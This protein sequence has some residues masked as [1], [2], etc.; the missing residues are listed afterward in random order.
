M[1]KIKNLGTTIKEKLN[2][3]M[4]RVKTDK[5]FCVILIAIV[6]AVIAA[7]IALVLVLGGGGA[8][9]GLGLG[10]GSGNNTDDGTK[11]AYTVSVKSKGG[12]PLGEVDVAI[13][14]A[15]D[16]NNLKDYAKTDENGLVNFQLGEDGN[17]IIVLTGVPKGYAVEESYTFDGTTAVISLTSSV[18]KDDNLT[19]AV[20]NEGDVM[21]DFTITT[22]DG[23]SYTLSEILKEKKMVLINYWYTTCSWCV[24]EFPVMAEAYEQYKDEIEIIAVNPMG[25]GEAAVKNFAESM[26]LPFPVVE[27]PSGWANVFSVTGY[28]TSVLIDQYGVVC[29]I[30]RGAITSLSP[31]VSAFEHFTA[32]DYQQKLCNGTIKSLYQQIKPNVSMPSS[33]EIASVINKGDIE[34]TY[35]PEEGDSAEYTWPFVIGDKNGTQCIYA[36]N[37]GIEDSYAILYADVTLKKGQALKL[38]YLSSTEKG[39]DIMYVIVNDEPI[40]NISGWEAEEKWQSC[41]PCIADEDGVYEVALCYI[42]DS[43]TNEGDDTVYIKGM[44]VVNESQIDTETYIPRL[45]AKE[46]EDGSYTYVDIVYNEADGYYHVGSKNGPL[47]LADLMNY[48][49]FNEEK[50][51]YELIY[52]D[53]E[54]EVNGKN[55]YDDFIQYCNYAS[56]AKITGVCTVNKELAEFLKEAASLYGFEDDD[57]EW[58]KMCKYY[59]AYG[60]N[61]HQL[62]D[63]IKGLAAF[64]AYKATLGKGVPTNYFYYDRAI[65]PRGLMAE[66]I[67]SVSGVYRIT[68]HNESQDG[69]DAWIF[70][71]NRE[72]ILT[73]ERDERMVA[74]YAD[75]NDVSMVYYMEAGTPYYIDIAFWD[76][77]EVGTITYDIEYLGASADIF[78]LA[79]PGY[80][81][82]DSDATG[83]AMYYVIA[84]GIDVVLNPAD[85]IYYEDLGKDA[86]G[87]QKYGSKLYADFTGLTP[88]FNSPIATNSGVKGM[89]DMGGF[90]FSKTENDLFVLSYLEKNNFDEEATLAALKEYWGEDSYEGYYDEYEVEDVFEGKYHGKGKDM[91]EDIRKYVS[92]IDTS[93]TEKNGCVVVTEELAEILQLIMDKYT[94]EDVD[95]SWTKLCYYYDHLGPEN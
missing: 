48:S 41:Y 35:R 10:H 56:N 30:E 3:L 84:G 4:E 36:P 16:T 92:Q 80:F 6:V 93:G 42:K 45:A 74:N 31:F 50:T 14:D 38:E 64:S 47:L 52:D 68:S 32:D 88:I 86:N 29:L 49:Q 75:D 37:I 21:Y 33:D 67:P 85:G 28:P 83:D 17:Y 76:V 15:E 7:I 55:V 70:N 20:L 43:D 51:I 53:G 13:Y 57:N 61:G 73:Y 78:R 87:K 46:T 8:G 22:A 5:K 59:A 40:F 66:F 62:E 44:S 26:Q 91:T 82:Y 11:V 34:V 90:D 19:S 1:E 60:S 12:L 27:V 65:I 81:T 2:V 39:N 79:S 54:F 77:Y 63:P 25:E 71:A 24:K 72:E 23:G 58:L 18:I 69:V 89:I 94:F 9:G 95:H